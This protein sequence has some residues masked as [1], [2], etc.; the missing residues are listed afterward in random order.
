[1][2]RET[3]EE[4]EDYLEQ[5]P[6]QEVAIDRGSA[7]PLSQ[8]PTGTVTTERARLGHNGDTTTS[9]GCQYLASSSFRG[10]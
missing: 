8:T 4:V 3:I 2:E 7:P 10:R 1:M 6:L 9:R 5:T